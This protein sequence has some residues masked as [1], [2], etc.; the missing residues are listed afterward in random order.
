MKNRV[1]RKLKKACSNY[2][3]GKPVNTRWG[4]F[5]QNCIRTY[6]YSSK[7]VDGKRTTLV[8]SMFFNRDFGKTKITENMKGVGQ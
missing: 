5:V 2:T 3:Y 8:C 1:P 4:R 6:S 7:V